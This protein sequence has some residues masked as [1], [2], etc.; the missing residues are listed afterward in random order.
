M[1]VAGEGK[2]YR[3]YDLCNMDFVDIAPDRGLDNINTKQDY[4]ELTAD[5]KE[6]AS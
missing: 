2:I 4:L 6:D 3:T 1:L 5:E